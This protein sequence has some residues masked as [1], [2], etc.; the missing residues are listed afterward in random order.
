MYSGGV[1]LCCVVYFWFRFFCFSRRFVLTCVVVFFVSLN[2]F[3]LGGDPSPKVFVNVFYPCAFLLGTT[4]YNLLF[5]FLAE[6]SPE[7]G[8]GSILLSLMFISGAMVAK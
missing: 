1:F 6:S 7:D 3:F 4:H 5:P 8:F 2:G